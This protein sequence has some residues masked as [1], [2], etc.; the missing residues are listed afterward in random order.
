MESK[1]KLKT[2]ARKTPNQVRQLLKNVSGEVLGEYICTINKMFTPRGV[3]ILDKETFA[4]Y[5][6]LLVVLQGIRDKRKK[7]LSSLYDWMI[8]EGIDKEVVKMRVNEYREREG[9]L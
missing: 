2:L 9:W 1:V 3:R 6:L 7:T 5:Q 4:R 8:S